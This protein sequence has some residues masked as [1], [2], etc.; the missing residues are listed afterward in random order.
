MIQQGRELA[1]K[2]VMLA[3]FG[4]NV[5]FLISYLI[6]HA[7]VLSKEFPKDPDVAPTSVRYGYYVLLASHVLLAALIPFMAVW[8]I[9]LGLKNRR[10]QHR[11]W[12]KWTWPVW[13]YVSVTG[14]IVYLMLYQIYVPPA[15]SNG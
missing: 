13:L 15:V 9:Y 7:N 2:R 8:T 12:A 11:R 4:V 3:T 14:V 1:H 6:Y 5:I 10:D